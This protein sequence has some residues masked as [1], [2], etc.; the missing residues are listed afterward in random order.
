MLRR[1]PSHPHQ[2]CHHHEAHL[3]CALRAWGR[4]SGHFQSSAKRLV[5]QWIFRC[6]DGNLLVFFRFQFTFGR[7]KKSAKV[8]QNTVNGQTPAP[9]GMDDAPCLLEYTVNPPTG[10]KWML[11]IS[12]LVACF[13]GV[14][15][16]WDVDFGAPEDSGFPFG[17]S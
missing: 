1:V 7:L 5:S 15:G 2:R 12:S 8:C 3:L 13:G 9:F 17:F 16:G 11:S 14:G 6:P 4:G 10:T